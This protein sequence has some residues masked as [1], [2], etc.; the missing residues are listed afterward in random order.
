MDFRE[1][2]AIYLQITEHICEQILN[3]KLPAGERIVSVREMAA[4]LEV[5]PNTV[6]RSYNELSD[7]EILQNKRGVGFFVSENAAEIIR[8]EQREKFIQE[9][10]PRFLKKMRLL[11]I[12]M[13]EIIQFEQDINK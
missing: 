12:R 8:N 5:N 3:G 4:A 11:G 10:L 6:M 1:E 2:K 7:K 9:E 13:S